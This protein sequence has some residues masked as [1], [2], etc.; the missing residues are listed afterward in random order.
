MVV[1]TDDG[2]DDLRLERNTTAPTMETIDPG[3]EKVDPGWERVDL[4]M[5]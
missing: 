5:Q 4:A 2:G 1:Q 3:W